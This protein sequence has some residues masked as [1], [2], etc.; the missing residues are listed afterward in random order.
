MAQLA[1]PS[2]NKHGEHKHAVGDLNKPNGVR[3][4]DLRSGTKVML[5]G[6]C[7]K[8]LG[9]TGDVVPATICDGS[10]K[11]MHEITR[12]GQLS[13][14]AGVFPNMDSRKIWV[15]FKYVVR[16]GHDTRPYS[17]GESFAISRAPPTVS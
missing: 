5:S 7:P 11:Q 1:P 9:A 16:I 4:G 12:D 3:W 6:D 15:A 2:E 13:L 14:A 10:E 17:S 8:I